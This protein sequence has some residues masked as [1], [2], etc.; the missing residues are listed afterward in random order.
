MPLG[1]PGDPEH[2]L[3]YPAE[4]ILIHTPFHVCFF[5]VSV[6]MKEHFRGIAV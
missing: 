3:L 2:V 6:F 1:S 5:H 4:I